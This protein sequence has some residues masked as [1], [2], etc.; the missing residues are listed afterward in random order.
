MKYVKWLVV[1]GTIFAISAIGNSAAKAAEQ[2]SEPGKVS[3]TAEQASAQPKEMW[4]YT[5]HNGEWWYWL[6]SNRWVYWRANKWNDYNPQTFTFLNAARSI[7]PGNASMTASQTLDGSDN[8]P[9]YGHSVS[10]WDTRPMEQNGEVGPFYGHTLPNEVF[11]P[12]RARR[13]IRPYYGHA[14][15]S[16]GD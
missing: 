2:K 9:F 1:C 13:S 11:G 16:V 7:S 10:G 12:W 14:E 6:R 15:F 8:R 3:T 4:R 5:F